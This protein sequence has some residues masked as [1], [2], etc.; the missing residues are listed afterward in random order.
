M[1]STGR[2]AETRS[3]VSRLQSG[4]PE[5]QTRMNGIIINLSPFCELVRNPYKLPHLGSCQAFLDNCQ[6]QALL[7]R[8]SLR[9]LKRNKRMAVKPARRW[10]MLPKTN[11]AA[12]SP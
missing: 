10:Y 7:P 5:R 6:P 3:A 2:A 4:V 1:V 11:N 9:P 12:D 8:G